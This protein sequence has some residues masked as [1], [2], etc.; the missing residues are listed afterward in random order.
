MVQ[1]R[2]VDVL[3]VQPKAEK[4]DEALKLVDD[5]IKQSDTKSTEQL[6]KRAQI[7][8][9]YPDR[10]KRNEAIAILERLVE[11]E[12]SVN[13]QIEERWL[14]ASLYQRAGNSEKSRDELRTIV[15]AKKDDLRALTGYI[16]LSLQANELSEAE[17]YL[18]SLKKYAPKDFT[19][20]DVEIQVLFKRRNFAEI[21]KLFKLINSRVQSG[22]DIEEI[23][24]RQLAIAR[25]YTVTASRFVEIDRLQDLKQYVSIEAESF[26]KSL[27]EEKPALIPLHAEFLAATHEI[28]RS[29]DL[30]QMHAAD[31]A[32]PVLERTS[33]LIMKNR[34]ATSEQLARLQELMKA[35]QGPSQ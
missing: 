28:D 18:N 29:L 10:E 7:L 26:F 5:Q 2:L 3:R 22:G 32:F 35:H 14:L 6:R 12:P 21:E 19:S 15:I 16:L 34:Y 1:L 17:L 24:R 9:M 8:A 25:L 20:V 30:M 23:S 33:R 13:I 27:I 31:V 4:L 11:K